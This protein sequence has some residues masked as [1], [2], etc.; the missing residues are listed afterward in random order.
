MKE[1]RMGT[2]SVP[3]LLLTMSV[4]IMGS[5][6]I[7][8][9]YNVVDSI[10]VA[11]ISENALSAVSMA[12][13]VQNL[14]IAI[15]VGTA[16]GMNALLSR[17]LGQKLFEK[18]NSVGEHGFFLAILS[19]LIFVLFGLFGARFFYETQT[20]IL[21]IIDQGEIYLRIV[22]LLS[23]G[24]FVQICCERLLQSTG[25]SIYAM[26][27]QG[28]GAVINIILDP[29]LIF[30]LF[31]AP[32][33]GVAG[34]AWATVIGQFC[35]ALLGIWMNRRYNHDIHLNFRK[36][37]PNLSIIREI[38]SVGLPSILMM[39][40]TSLSTYFINKV[41]GSF[42]STAVAAFGVFVKVQSFVLMPLF[43]VTNGM[44]PIVAY[45]YGAGKV[46]RLRETVKLALISGFVITFSGFLLIQLGAP[47]ILQTFDAGGD[48]MTIGVSAL[49][50]ISTSFILAGISIVCSAL[51][52]ALGNGMLSMSLSMFRQLAVLVPAVYL[53]SLTGEL[54][55]IWLAFPL[56]EVVCFLLCI[57]FLRKTFREKVG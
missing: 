10:F 17:S 39:S 20:D 15:A 52:Q 12:F 4:P 7:Q 2:E 8:A 18:A 41:A 51:F 35:G 57:Y 16:V 53:L 56:A 24:V 45:N 13:P 44:V 38:Y 21:E 40:I 50:T 34:A 29:I 27:T 1:N 36:F 48:L 28:M 47:R 33:M 46:H 5:M 30:G 19:S 54:S 55:L 11:R 32:E 42:T 43:G 31:G 9:L 37:R 25:R 26:V 22:T 3:K 23:V 14:L 6:L 49:R